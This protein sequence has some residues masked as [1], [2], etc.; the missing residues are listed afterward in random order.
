MGLTTDD[1]TPLYFED[2]LFRF[3]TYVSG[4]YE[5]GPHE[6]AWL[7]NVQK[8]GPVWDDYRGR[9]VLVGVVGTVDNLHPDLRA[10]YHDEY[11]A[12]H[13]PQGDIAV[14]SNPMGTAMA[15]IIAAD[16][17]GE[18]LVGMAPDAQVFEFT[19]DA[20]EAPDIVV[21][22]SQPNPYERAIPVLIDTAARG[23]LGRITIADSPGDDL[24]DHH[25]GLRDDPLADMD[26]TVGYVGFNQSNM[27]WLNSQFTVHSDR[28]VITANGMTM[29]GAFPF[30]SGVAGP[31]TLVSAPMGT[32]AYW[33]IFDPGNGLDPS[34]PNFQAGYPDWNVAGDAVQTLVLDH[35]ADFG[36]QKADETIGVYWSILAE[37]ALGVEIDRRGD[38]TDAHAGGF[39]SAVVGGAV[40]L[41]LEAEPDLGW[42]D[43]QAVLAYSANPIRGG[44]IPFLSEYDTLDPN[45]QWNAETNW[46][47]A[48]LMYSEQ[49]GFGGLDTRA[50]VRLAETWLDGGRAARTSAN[51]ETVTATL[52]PGQQL[53]YQADFGEQIGWFDDT[54]VRPF[55]LEFVLPEGIEIEH[56]TLSVDVSGQMNS[57][58]SEELAAV[59][60][61]QIVS[62]EAQRSLVAG[63]SQ[64][65]RLPQST[66]FDDGKWVNALD[67][68]FTSR[69]FWGQ[70]A[71]AGE[72][73][74]VIVTPGQSLYGYDEVHRLE[75]EGMS[76]T[77]HGAPV[78]QDDVY[79][80][81]DAVVQMLNTAAD[82]DQGFTGTIAGNSGHGG[83]LR[84]GAGRD[85]LNASAMSYDLDL[86][87][88][89]GGRGTAK[90]AADGGGDIRFYTLATGTAM[91]SLLS[92]D[93]D[94]V[95][96][97]GG[98]AEVLDS[99]RGV[100]RIVAGGGNDTIRA[101]DGA[102][103]VEAGSGADAVW[104]GSGGDRIDGG[105]GDDVLRG[106]SGADT[107]SGGSGDDRIE[108]GR[109]ADR[110]DGGSGADRIAGGSG[111]DNVGGGSGDDRIV[112]GS[113]ADAIEGGS[114][115]DRIEGGSGRDRLL[116]GSGNDRLEG[117]SG[118]DRLEGGSGNDRID[119]GSGDDR[120]EG[121]SGADVFVF[122]RGGGRDVVVDFRDDLDTLSID[123]RLVGPDRVAAVMDEA[124]QQGSDVVFDFGGGDVLIVE[125]TTVRQLTNDVELF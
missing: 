125:D 28:H 3:Q 69:A 17:N 12:H 37:T 19:G 71:E 36:L 11:L 109:S 83:T 10:N 25:F 15:G 16:D 94:D 103:R 23:G 80:Y 120:L 104:G 51:E 8:M 21:M 110:V 74:R 121:G 57:G 107:I 31:M 85:V 91:S 124:R 86:S 95:L 92:G 117:G 73:W 20:A 88:V 32:S 40:A 93:G 30:S 4:R 9:D 84:D 63:T 34:D 55:A 52:K 89:A 122:A 49:I 45:V 116:G 5:I 82:A 76:L 47:G 60:G 111:A 62:P 119:G 6:I 112:T 2:D 18:G 105:S 43:V 41:M 13:D 70:T 90:G 113:G 29:T 87:A 42:R 58:G 108:G 114:G 1:T 97:G 65:A 24:S 38:Y 100:D 54:P 48:G 96:R 106:E 22:G 27:G 14:G 72:T 66:G 59:M 77:F 75:I 78:S 123:D 98:R 81:T 33:G 64:W 118:D 26:E 7:T 35:R 101:G 44:N 39:A 53:T 68:D 102:D 61:F 50:A 115:A 46:N 56:V 79:V 99:G 67:Y